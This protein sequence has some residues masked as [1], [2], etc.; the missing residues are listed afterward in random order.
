MDQGAPGRIR[1]HLEGSESTWKDQGAPGR[2]REHLEGSGSPRDGSGNTWMDQGAPGRIREH[3]EGSGN[4]WDGSGSTWMDQR[5]PGMDQGAPGRIR[6]HL[7]GSGSTWKDQG[8]LGMDQGTPGRARAPRL[9]WRIRGAQPPPAP[10]L[11]W[12]NCSCWNLL[13]CSWI[14]AGGPGSGN[15]TCPC[16]TCNPAPFQVHPGGSRALQVSPLSRGCPG[17][18]P[19]P[20]LI[21]E[22]QVS[23]RNLHLPPHP[24]VL[25]KAPP[26]PFQHP[27]SVPGA[28]W[29]LPGVPLDVPFPGN[30]LLERLEFLVL[31]LG[32]S[33]LPRAPCAGPNWLD[34]DGI[35]CPPPGPSSPSRGR[36]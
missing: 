24:P 5:T 14:P 20:A 11:G 23:S 7:D 16:P 21:H 22:L 4:T 13:E 31:P 18:S 35:Q 32:C 28:P 34:W 25:P 29:V 8:A 6:E 15:V 27:G 26:P 36:E 17:M 30:P 3:L 12:T 19:V 1:E 2:I 10:H 9:T 33:H